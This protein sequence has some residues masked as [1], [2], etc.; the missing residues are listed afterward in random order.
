M[1]LRNS[2]ATLYQKMLARVS[3][4]YADLRL[5]DMTADPDFP[6]VINR[7]RHV[8]SVF[9]YVVMEL[10]L[11]IF[12]EPGKIEYYESN[13]CN[14][15]AHTDIDIKRGPG[16]S[17]D[18]YFSYVYTDGVREMSAVIFSCGDPAIFMACLVGLVFYLY[19]VQ[20]DSRQGI[21]LS[22]GK[23]NSVFNLR[24]NYDSQIV[25]LTKTIM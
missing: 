24:V 9:L 3:P 20:S 4:Q 12:P 11:L 22:S 5:A 19:G 8:K 15:C 1:G 14:Y 23:Q 18:Y 10:M 2:D 25:T 7:F 21:L 6:P 16:I 13:V 17:V